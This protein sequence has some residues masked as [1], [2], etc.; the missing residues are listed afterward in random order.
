LS[1]TAD[2]QVVNK[3]PKANQA[4]VVNQMEAVTLEAGQ[5]YSLHAQAN[6]PDGDALTYSWSVPANMQATGADTANLNITA[7][8]VD[9]ES[10]YTLTVVVSDGKSSVQTNVQVTVTPKAAETPSDEGNTPSDEGNT[11]SDEGNTHPMKATRRLTKVTP[12]PMKA[13]RRRRRF[14]HQ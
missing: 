7:P 9:A 13:I 8:D 14:C 6:D 3:A 11:P 10:T 5:S 2:V 1:S 4:P 12:H